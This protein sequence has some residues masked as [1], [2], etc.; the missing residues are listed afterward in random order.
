MQHTLYRF[1]FYVDNI[2]LCQRAHTRCHQKKSP[3][4]YLIRGRFFSIIG[5][6]GVNGKNTSL[7]IISAGT[8]GR[9]LLSTLPGLVS[10]YS[11]NGSTASWLLKLCRCSASFPPV[12]KVIFKCVY[13][14]HRQS[15]YIFVCLIYL[16]SIS[17]WC[18]F[19]LIFS[20]LVL[21]ISLVVRNLFTNLLLTTSPE[22]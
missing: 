22:L 2:I 4:V 15:Y 17:P 12:N 18:Y 9:R 14:L 19:S 3:L 7:W 1:V 8:L 16:S 11:F 6:S 5:P 13:L 10:T 20:I 21:G